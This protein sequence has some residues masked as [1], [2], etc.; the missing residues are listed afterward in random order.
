MKIE[1]FIE[2][3][4]KSGDKL[5]NIK[6]HV[7]KDYVNFERKIAIAEVISKKMIA[8]SGDLIKNTPMVYMN[9][10]VCLIKEYTDIEFAETDSLAAFNM[11]EKNGV[12]ELLASAIGK[13]ATSFETVLKMVINDSVENH[14]NLV[15]HLSLKGDNINFILGKVEEILKT[16]ATRIPAVGTVNTGNVAQSW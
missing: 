10:I 14:N 6:K 4:N 3:F 2:E 16:Q 8:P 1:E 7:V 15:N 12:S 11:L 13:D 9:L 5:K